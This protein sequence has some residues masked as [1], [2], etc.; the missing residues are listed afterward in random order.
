M[1]KISIELI[2]NNTISYK[3]IQPE[4]FKA[5][6]SLGTLVHGEGY[7]NL[8]NLKEWVNKG[9][10]HDINTSFVAYEH[11]K[12]VGFRLTYSVGQWQLDQWCSPALWKSNKTDVCYFKC[13]TVDENYRGYG[14]GSKLLELSIDA[15][16]KQ[17]AIAGV[18][19]L[20][21]QSP[22]NSAVK[23]FTKC[24]GILIKEHSERWNELSLQG[25]ECPACDNQCHCS[26]AEM[27]IYFD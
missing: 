11:D 1:S 7:I 17:G 8:I 27:M 4:D 3:T 25:Y 2:M 26:A 20:W 14:I 22:G 19:H 10:K 9:L 23:Y 16:K 5:V 15:A 12:L 6:V 13:N 18:S 24:G 21:M